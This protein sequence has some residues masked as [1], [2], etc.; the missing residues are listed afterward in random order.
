M[1]TPLAGQR[2]FDDLGTP[3]HE[4]TFVVLDLETTGGSPTE[5]AI[6]ELGAVRYRGGE[7]LGTF[8]TL[9]HPGRSIPANVAVLTG[10]TDALVGPAPRIDAVLPSF[11]DFCSGGVIVGHNVRFDLGFLRRASEATGWPALEGPVV[12]T[13]ALARRLLA[14]EVP[15]HRLRTLADRLRLPHRP[16]HRALSDAE[17]TADLLHAL[18][19]RAGRLGVMGLDDLLTLPT[20]AGHPQSAKL[21]MTDRLP[22]I[23]G[24][25]LF[26]DKRG[27]VLYV[28]KAADIRARVRSYFSSERRRKVAS[29]LREVESVD[30]RVMPGPFAPEIAELRLIH[31]LVPRFNRQHRR[32]STV[33]LELTL[34]EPFPRLMAARKLKNDGGLYVGPFS[35]RRQVD[36]LV[37]AVHSVSRLRRCT[38]R[39]SA[40]RPRAAPCASGQ[41]GVALCPCAGDESSARYADEVERVRRGLSD[42]PDWLVEPLVLRMREL[43]ATRRFEEA[44]D[45][46]DRAAALVGA[47]DRQ[48]RVE[49]LIGAGRMR[50]TVPRGEAEIEDG[51]LVAARDR[52]GRWA[53]LPEPIEGW[54]GQLDEARM[55]VSLLDRAAGRCRV[56]E[57]ADEWSTPLPRLP[58][59]RVRGG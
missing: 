56:A 54:V 42:R 55:L 26:R 5:D 15:N 1:T 37:E 47:L 22:R 16:S 19:E 9:V 18:L 35:S 33:W 28:G 34:G 10:I 11:L 27:E 25:Y 32:R 59:L 43:A 36:V 13:L 8:S 44:A 14:D 53:E 7:L 51:R 46:R 20:M 57:V 48:R 39:P 23:P 3:L 6:T 31:S 2:S 17:A 58:D 29:L 45:A 24:V 49:A 38:I 12:D 50:I 4:V 40:S 52:D 41:L 30:H 21:R